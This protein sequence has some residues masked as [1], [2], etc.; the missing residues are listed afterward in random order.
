MQIIR[1]ITLISLLHISGCSAIHD[2]CALVERPLAKSAIKMIDSETVRRVEIRCM[3]KNTV[4]FAPLDPDSLEEGYQY[5]FII[6]GADASQ[7]ARELISC[8][9]RASISPAQDAGNIRWGC[10]FYDFNEV[11]VLSVYFDELGTKGSI[12]GDTVTSNGAFVRF[13]EDRCSCLRKS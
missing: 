8:L 6:K 3:E 1:S 4:T 10:I 2:Q 5:M 12:N 7:L 11:R 13:L 9:K